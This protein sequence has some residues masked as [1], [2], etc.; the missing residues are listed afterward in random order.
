VVTGAGD[1]VKLPAGGYKLLYGAVLGA[2]GQIMAAMVPGELPVYQLASAGGD[3]KK[4]PTF[5]YGGPFELHFK[6]R[7]KDGKLA[8]EPAITLHGAGGEG[9][10]DFRWQGT[11]TVYVN[12][13]QNGSMGF[14]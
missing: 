14:G 10:V 1:V 11:P 9:Y 3:A 6:A 7:V 2:K 4:K 12:G 8:V 13:K 5:A